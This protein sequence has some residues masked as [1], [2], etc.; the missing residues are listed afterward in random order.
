MAE[1][2]S[3][4]YLNDQFLPL[5]EARISVLDRGF[6]FSDGIYEVIPVYNNRLFRLTEHLQ[7]L[8]QSLQGIRLTNPFSWETWKRILNT[9]VQDNAPHHGKNQ[10]IYL[11]ITR[12]VAHRDHAFPR[13]VTPT[14]F[15]MSSPLPHPTAATQEQGIAGITLEDIRWRYCHLKTTALLPN[16]LLRQQALEA[17]ASEAILIRDGLVTEGAASNV[18]IVK[19]KTLITVPKGS[20][21][22][23]GITRDVILELAEANGIGWRETMISE[24]ELRTAEEIWV[25][26]SIREI[27]PVTWLD[28]QPINGGRPGPLWARMVDLYQEYKQSLP[29][30]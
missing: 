3:I 5:T 7:R 15:A 21:M 6:L 29:S 1:P 11:Q 24:S 26:S 10:Y 27:V 22:L 20:H 18:C 12:G 9:L 17:G 14:V 13:E 16:V 2:N 19:D 25:T 28:G 8:E 30:S 4:A 23:S